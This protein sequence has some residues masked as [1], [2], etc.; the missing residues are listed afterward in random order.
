MFSLAF[1]IINICC[2]FFYNNVHRLR[3]CQLSL[4][5]DQT[6]ARVTVMGQ[7]MK[8]LLNISYIIKIWQRSLALNVTFW[9]VTFN[10]KVMHINTDSLQQDC[11]V[12]N[13]K[14]NA[15]SFWL[16]RQNEIDIFFCYFAA[17]GWREN[18]ALENL[19]L[20]QL[21]VWA[22]LTF[23]WKNKNKQETLV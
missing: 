15:T 2:V 4:V 8:T 17:T 1:L 7:T 3:K 10:K 21:F 11:L 23:S 5:T 13:D 18:K 12:G 16:S 6:Q 9:S 14:C 22:R 19:T 20:L